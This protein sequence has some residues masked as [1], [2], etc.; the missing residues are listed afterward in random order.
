MNLERIRIFARKRSAR[1]GGIALRSQSN[2]RSAAVPLVHAWDGIRRA[3]GEFLTL[4]SCIIALFVLVAVGAHALDRSRPAAFETARA[5]LTRHIF[6]NAQATQGLLSTIASGI[7]TITSI[8]ISLLLI[9]LQQSAGSMT[10]RVFDQYLRRWYNQAFFGYFVGLS[11]YTLLILATVN[12][13]FNPVFGGTVGLLFMIVALFLLIAL[14]YSTINQTRPAV[15]IE[16]VHDLALGARKRQHALLA[17]TQ[18]A[19]A[20]AG[21]V[22]RPVQTDEDGFVTRIDVPGIGAATQNRRIQV[23]F[24]VSIGS[25]VAHGDTI[26]HVAAET[27]EDADAMLGA[28]VDRVHIE[29][30]RN[31]RIDP[32]YAIAQLETIGWTSVSSAKHNP[33]AGLL[34]VQNLRDIL[35][36]WAT[37]PMDRAAPAETGFSAVYEDNTLEALMNAFASLAVV[38]SESRQ[39]MVFSAILQALAQ[40]FERLESTVRPRIEDLVLRMLPALV[41]HAPTR[42]LDVALSHLCA[43]LQAASCGATAAA[44][45]AARSQL[46]RS[47]GT[48]PSQSITLSGDSS[49]VAIEPRE[50]SVNESGSLARTTSNAR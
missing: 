38:S 18:R 26:A 11:L 12:S 24:R 8:T 13:P 4:P 15:I 32:A 19:P 10:A 45:S 21:A 3:Y 14:L 48:L 25:Y 7:I 37:T 17:G 5:L 44:V 33:A 30:Q 46:D 22:N 39:H 43:V 23:V 47:I 49:S 40:T 34:V 50:S 27:C 6:S 42:E 35:A 16:A 20:Y 41:D 1:N 28:I 36:R 31:V 2:R 29:R 9:A